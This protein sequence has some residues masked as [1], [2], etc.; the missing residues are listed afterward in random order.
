[1]AQ[2]LWC[3]V[4]LRTKWV[5][6]L[7]DPQKRRFSVCL[8][9]KSTKKRILA[10]SPGIPNSPGSWR[11]RRTSLKLP[12]SKG[13]HPKTLGQQPILSVEKKSRMSNSVGFPL[14]PR[15]KARKPIGFSLNGSTGNCS[16][17]PWAT[18]PPDISSSRPLGLKSPRC[19][20]RSEV[21]H[22]RGHREDFRRRVL[23]VPR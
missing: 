6:S 10:I 4:G 22:S 7:G 5:F 2:P 15:G 14:K 17:V 9:F 20:H 3:C 8:S 11:A 13:L 18:S 12:I 16:K 21:G 23:R 1:M 19:H